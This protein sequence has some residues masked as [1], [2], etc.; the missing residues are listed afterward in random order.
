MSGI[1]QVRLDARI[2]QTGNMFYKERESPFRLEVYARQN[3]EQKYDLFENLRKLGTFDVPASEDQASSHELEAELY[4]GEVLGFRWADGPIFSD[5]GRREVSHDFI[6]DRLLNDRS[7]YAAAIKLNGGKRGSTQIEF[8]EAIR[9]LMEGGTLDLSDP[10]LERRPEIYG[11]GLSNGP[12]NWSKAYAQEEMHRFGPGLDILGVSIEGPHKV[13]PDQLTRQRLARSKAFLGPRPDGIEDIEFAE[14]I[15]RRFLPEAFRRPVT[16]DQ[17][18]EYLEVVRT[19]LEEFPEKRVEEGIHLAIRRALISPRFLFRGLKPGKLDD[20]DLASR[21]SYF[22]TS[23][24]PDDRLLA[25]AERGELS[26]ESVL[27]SEVQRLLA[28]PERNE[29]VRHFTGQW[30]STRKLKDVMPDPRLVR[31]LLATGKP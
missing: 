11:G 7:F 15:L 26:D 21:L 28:K 29:F 4:L 9:D 17:L 10:Q 24:P 22:L 19:H 13:I 25:L 23:G 12:H 2:F 31:F 30:L 1:Y 18:D 27:E 16:D 5:P 20:W 8:F 3:S 14:Q 6:D